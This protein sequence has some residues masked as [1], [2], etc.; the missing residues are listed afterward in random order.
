MIQIETKSILIGK[1]EPTKTYFHA[2]K[3]VVCMINTN[4]SLLIILHSLP[5]NRIMLIKR[6]LVCLFKYIS[7]IPR[8]KSRSGKLS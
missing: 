6:L 3:Q 8:K 4:L 5:L 2:K 7:L 1:F